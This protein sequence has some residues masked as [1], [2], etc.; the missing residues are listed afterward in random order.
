MMPA[1]TET[2]QN[3]LLFFTDLADQREAV[4]TLVEQ[5]RTDSDYF[6]YLIVSGLIACLGLLNDNPV[7]VIGAML[8]APALFPILSLGL[9]VVTRSKSATFRAVRAIVLSFVAVVLTSSMMGFMFKTMV[10]EELNQTILL[11]SSPNATSWIVA[12]LSG[13]V[14]SY[15]WVKQSQSAMLPGVAIAVSLVPPLANIGLGI[16]LGSTAVFIGSLLTFIINIIMIALVSVF[17]FALFGFADMRNWQ[18][19]RLKQEERDLQHDKAKVGNTVDKITSDLNQAA[20][21]ESEL[22]DSD[23]E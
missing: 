19:L 5:S 4:D 14:G 10:N 8:I 11:A 2:K 9:A 3:D 17:I 18:L 7:V 12:A 23:N 13:L 15:A 20:A 22:S 16:V 1:N 21:E 6:F